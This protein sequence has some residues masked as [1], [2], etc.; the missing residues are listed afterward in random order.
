MTF[1]PKR[2]AKVFDIYLFDQILNLCVLLDVIGFCKINI[3]L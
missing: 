2:V 1:T 3:T